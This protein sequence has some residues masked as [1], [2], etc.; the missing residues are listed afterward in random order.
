MLL[1]QDGFGPVY[2]SISG[3]SWERNSGRARGGNR[4]ATAELDGILPG[5]FARLA[6]FRLTAA[7]VSLKRGAGLSMMQVRAAAE[8][9]WRVTERE[10]VQ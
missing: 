8:P 10:E 7:Q 4:A 5:R 3:E 1:P 6:A 9:A 2:C